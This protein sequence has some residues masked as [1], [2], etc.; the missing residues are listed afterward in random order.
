MQQEIKPQRPRYFAAPIA[1]LPGGNILTCD[2][3]ADGG[4]GNLG[5]GAKSKGLVKPEPWSGKHVHKTEPEMNVSVPGVA[6]GCRWDYEENGVWK[7]VCYC[8]DKDGC[9]S[10]SVLSASV[11]LVSVTLLF[12]LHIIR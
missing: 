4:G 7:E 1:F 9:N 5:G 8:E 11:F 2:L 6:W 3:T 12:I 10:S